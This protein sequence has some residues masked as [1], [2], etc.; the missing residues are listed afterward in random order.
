MD[1]T[2]ENKTENEIR[3]KVAQEVKDW[4]KAEHDA[5]RF[6]MLDLFY[7]LDQIGREDRK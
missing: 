2:P 5:C 3:R 4:I 6:C 7:Y 1:S